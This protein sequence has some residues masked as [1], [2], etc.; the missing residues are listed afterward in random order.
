MD[1]WGGQRASRDSAQFALA[2]QRV[3]SGHRGA[4]ACSAAWPTRY[5]QT[6]SLQEQSRI[7]EL[8]LANAQ[9]RARNWCRPAST[10]A[11][12]R[13]WNWPSRKAWWRRSNGNCR[14]CSNRPKDAQI[15][16]AALLGRPVQDTGAGPGTLRSIDLARHRRRRAQPVAQPPPGHRPGRSAT[17]RRPGRRHRRPRRDVADRDPERRNRLR[18]RHVPATFCAARSTT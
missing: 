12:R 3:R 16:L 17:G 11:R 4:D 8:N 18:R 14:W 6:L 2:G 7:A 1:F 13:R 9:Q 5:A 15:S 10:R